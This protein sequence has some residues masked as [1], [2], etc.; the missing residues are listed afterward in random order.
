MLAWLR[1]SSAHRRRPARWSV[2][3]GSLV[4]LLVAGPWILP[5]AGERSMVERELYEL[6]EDYAEQVGW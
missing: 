2:V 1:V 4:T 3:G 6:R 5:V